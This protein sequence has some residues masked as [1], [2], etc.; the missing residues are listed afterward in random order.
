MSREVI[1]A[2]WCDRCDALERKTAATHTYTI[3]IVK[4][5]NRP[6]LRVVELCDDHDPMLADLFDLL[7]KNSIPLDPDALKPAAPSPAPARRDREECR[8]CGA[9][10]ARSSLITHV[11][12][13]HRAGETRPAPPVRCPECRK[14]IPPAGMS[15][16]R[17]RAHGVSALDE[18]Y[19]GLIA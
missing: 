18:A 19:S 11:W 12:T 13:Q 8:V 5:E 10:V 1:I 14:S 16:H 3:G 2:S 4:G 9:E 17:N 7:A 15:M 6:A